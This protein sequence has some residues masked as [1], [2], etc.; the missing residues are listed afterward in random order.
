MDKKATLQSEINKVIVKLN[1]SPNRE[2]QQ[3]MDS[4]PLTTKEKRRVTKKNKFMQGNHINDALELESDIRT[5]LFFVWG[6]ILGIAGSY[7][8][9]YLLESTNNILKI[10][11]FV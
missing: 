4:I 2:D 5:K 8:A 3:E 1:R 9:S 11:F 10:V 7:F 6:I